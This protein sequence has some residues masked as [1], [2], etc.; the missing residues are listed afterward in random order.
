MNETEKIKFIGYD[1][2][3]NKVD[4]TIT[5]V[6]ERATMQIERQFSPIEDIEGYVFLKEKPNFDKMYKIAKIEIKKVIGEYD[7][8]EIVYLN[9]TAY[10]M[11]EAG[12]T[13]DTIRS[14]K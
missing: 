14:E 3:G 7:E 11:N 5:G 6:V 8:D 13:V 10:V 9:G 4:R 2:N 12:T 1:L